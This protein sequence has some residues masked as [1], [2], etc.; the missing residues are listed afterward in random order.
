MGTAMLFAPREADARRLLEG[1]KKAVEEERDRAKYHAM[2]A[3]SARHAIQLGLALRAWEWD[4]VAE[5]ERILGEEGEALQQT[6]EQRHLLGLCRRKVLHLF[7]HKS[8]VT[9]VAIS[10]DGNRIASGSLYGELTVWDARTGADL[11]RIRVALPRSCGVTSVAFSQDGRLIVSGSM[12]GTVKVWE[13]PL[14]EGT[15]KAP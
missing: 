5:A 12:D 3:E 9:G 1:E 2:R 13:A 11:H 15:E 7:G 4:D 6:W 10:P 8:R 14:A